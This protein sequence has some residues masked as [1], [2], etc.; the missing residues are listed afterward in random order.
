M[1]PTNG[2][3]AVRSAD[4]NRPTVADLQG[5]NHYTQFARK[6]WL[7]GSAVNAK[8]I[9]PDFLKKE[10]W[11][12]LESEGFQYKSLLILENLQCLERY[13]RLTSS[14]SALADPVQLSMAWLQ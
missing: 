12:V 10:L 8:T 1:A 14:L 3:L 5:D 6:T 2:H 9:K 13:C 7:S 4:H 11:D